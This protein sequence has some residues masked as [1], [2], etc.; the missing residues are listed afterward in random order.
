MGPLAQLEHGAIDGIGVHRPP[1][2]GLARGSWTLGVGVN[3]R[4]R[5]LGYTVDDAIRYALED[6]R[7][8]AIYEG[9]GLTHLL[10][11]R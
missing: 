10:P 6:G 2:P 8:P 4:Y 5:A 7:I 11:E 9:Y 1:L 3:F